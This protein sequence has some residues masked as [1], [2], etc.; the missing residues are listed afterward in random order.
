MNIYNSTNGTFYY[1][2]VSKLTIIYTYT[3][4]H[5]G[6][7]KTNV[8]GIVNGQTGGELTSIGKQQANQ[9]G[10]RLKDI[11]FDNVY[12]S[13]LHRTKQTLDRILFHQ[14]TSSYT[15][16]YEKLLREIN[17]NS[18]EG[19]PWKIEDDMRAKGEIFRFTK[20]GDNGDETWVDVWYRASLILTKVIK[21]FVNSEFDS[22]I[23]EDNYNKLNDIP[24]NELLVKK[25]FE[26]NFKKGEYTVK[27]GIKQGQKVRRVL[28]VTHGGVISEMINVILFWMRKTMVIELQPNNTCL[29]K[30]SVFNKMDDVVNKERVFFSIDVINDCSHVTE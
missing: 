9:L 21:E 28:M 17:V 16:S 30:V 23:T 15:L 24:N 1:S 5:S 4:I 20:T 12:C 18:V 11:K 8:A 22:E 29:F 19:L 10:M 26:E 14:E 7:T 13:D 6:Q 2:T 3:P 27:D 25:Q